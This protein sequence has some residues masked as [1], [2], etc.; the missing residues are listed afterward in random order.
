M[1]VDAQLDDLSPM[2]KEYGR[3]LRNLGAD[4]R[5]RLPKNIET[6]THLVWKDGD[7]GGS[8]WL[9]LVSRRQSITP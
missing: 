6:L 1:H 9:V 7:E 5:E 4:V 8:H 3:L 2:N